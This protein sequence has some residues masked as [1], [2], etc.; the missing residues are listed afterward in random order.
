MGEAVDGANVVG[1]QVRCRAVPDVGTVLVE[2]QHRAL[3]AARLLLHQAHQGVEDLFERAASGNHPEHVLLRRADRLVVAP[4]GDVA[5]D[6]QQ[7]DDVAVHA[8]NRRHGDVPPPARTG[9]RWQ[10]ALKTAAP[11]GARL[12]D[13]RGGRG[14][15]VPVEEADQRAV[16][17]VRRVDIEGAQALPVHVNQTSFEVEDLDAVA[18]MLGNPPVDLLGL[19][20]RLF[21]ALAVGDVGI[22]AGHADGDARRVSR[23]RAA[24][25]EPPD[26][27]VAVDHPVFDLVER[28]LARDVRLRAGKHGRAVVGMHEAAPVVDVIANLPILVAE[29]LFEDGI[30]VDLAR[31]EIPVPD[32]DT[33][34]RRSA[35]VAVVSEHDAR[36]NPGLPRSPGRPPPSRCRRRTA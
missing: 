12:G 10:Q 8:G 13:G 20:Q 7:L 15:H 31:G 29:S 25:E 14:P 28:R 34:C 17:H 11:A 36:S 4:L 27:A 6:C 33:A 19:A 32:A 35:P 30:D 24:R 3:H 2:Q 22:G 1:G 16:E 18:G 23:H 9:R 21:A 26:A 5:R